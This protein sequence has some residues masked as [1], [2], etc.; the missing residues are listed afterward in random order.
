MNFLDNMT[1]KAKLMLLTIITLVSLLAVALSG[2]HGINSCG[3]ALIEVSEVRLP[4]VLG[5]EIINEGQTAIK[6]NMLETPIYELDYNARDKFADTVKLMGTTQ[7]LANNSSTEEQKALFKEFYAQYETQR[8]SFT[9]A[10]TTLGKIID[11]NIDIAEVAQKEGKVTISFSKN[12]MIISALIAIIISI[13]FSTLITKSI[14]SSLNSIQ[15]GL[16]SFFSFL[17]RETDRAE[18]INLDSKDEFGQMAVVINDNIERVKKSI[19][20]DR[21]LIDETITVLG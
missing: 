9:P 17:N 21:R 12:T 13:L 19:D 15:S 8:K 16:Q 11:L 2:N 3:S 18:S 7:K 1:V 6:A 14:T 10:E 20:E 4:S 5:L